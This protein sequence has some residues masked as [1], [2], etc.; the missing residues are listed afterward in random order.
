MRVVYKSDKSHQDRRQ[1]KLHLQCVSGIHF[2]PVDS[3]QT[4][5]ELRDLVELKNINV[6]QHKVPKH[7][8]DAFPEEGDLLDPNDEVDGEVGFALL[9]MELDEVVCHHVP[10]PSSCRIQIRDQNVCALMDSGA[11]VNLLSTGLHTKLQGQDGVQFQ[12]IDRRIVGISQQQGSNGDFNSPP[13]CK[14]Y[15][16]TNECGFCNHCR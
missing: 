15:Y 13:M 4:D 11:Q 1:R 12:E 10:S 8:Q 2:N 9:D 6:F 7:T 16:S 3:N 14:G 5:D